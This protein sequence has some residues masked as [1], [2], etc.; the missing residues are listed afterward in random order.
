MLS[1]L[2]P[3]TEGAEKCFQ[4]P[5]SWFSP[6]EAEPGETWRV[7]LA[8]VKRSSSAAVPHTIFTIRVLVIRN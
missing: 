7:P 2:V 6:V 8:Y 3:I 5:K 1:R 4:M